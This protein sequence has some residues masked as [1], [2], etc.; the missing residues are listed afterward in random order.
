MQASADRRE[1]THSVRQHWLARFFLVPYHIGWHLAHHVDSG[2]PWRNLPRYHQLLRESGYVTPGLE[3]A[4]YPALWR[5]LSSRPPPQPSR[6]RL[7]PSLGRHHPQRQ[8]VLEHEHRLGRAHLGQAVELH[9]HDVAERLHVGHPD[10]HDE[11]EGAAR[12]REVLHSGQLEQRAGGRRA[13]RPG[14]R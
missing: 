11:V 9:E 1:T 8:V 12:E 6:R 2:V 7:A 3:Y 14:P 13:S 10:E 5:K 4:G